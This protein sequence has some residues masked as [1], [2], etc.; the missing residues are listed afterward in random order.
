[1][2]VLFDL[3]KFY[4]NI[5]RVFMPE[6]EGK[7]VI[8]LSNND[9]CSICYSPG[10]LKVKLPI[11]MGTPIF[12]VEHLV[13]KYNIIVYS[14]NFP[15]IADISLRVKS[16]MERFCPRFEDYSIDEVIA[17]FSGIDNDK[18]EAIC[19]KIVNLIGVGLGLPI[20][21]GIGTSTTLAKAACRFAKKH[22]GYNG[23]C[24]IDSE[25][26][27]EKALKLLDISDV[28]GI[29]SEYSAM[30]RYYNV[31]TAYDFTQKPAAW[32]RKQMT[33]TGLRTHQ[34]LLGI[35]C[36]PLEEVAKPKKNIVVSRS[37]GKMIQDFETIAE[38]LTTYAC[39]A[40]A[41]LRKQ[42]SKTKAVYVFLET[43]P[44]RQDLPQL[45]NSIVINLPVA[46][47]SS[48]EIA[49]Y[50]KKGL[51]ALYR[52]GYD[53]KITGIGLMK[54]SPKTSVQLNIFD[55]ISGERRR[56]ED[57]LMVT[58]DSIN[59]K[60]GRNTCTM[61]A[62]GDGKKWWI[63]QEKLPPYWTTRESDYPVAN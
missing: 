26:K 58:V 34:E 29:G 33:V 11:E 56:K 57:L 27:R 3:N 4:A 20:S 38:A 53:F 44:F 48:I 46:T 40:A 7:P 61:T 22:K 10:N 62:Q 14:C 21:A 54:I 39:M 2:I 19:R 52:Q 28:W 42:G 12:E 23:V 63:R 60:Y 36:I 50:A 16:I 15:L 30:L 35:P 25:E 47:S 13:R 49:K 43:N 9:G 18:V 55:P 24:M 51:W 8:I 45:S 5:I 59:N 1:M 41:K 32:V 6:L 37:F 17:D 31:K